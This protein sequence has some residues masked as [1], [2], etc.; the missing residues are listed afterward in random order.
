[1]IATLH[2]SDATSPGFLVSFKQPTATVL[3][4]FAMQLRSDDR[5]EVLQIGD[6]LIQ[7]EIDLAQYMRYEAASRGVSIAVIHQEEMEA[8]RAIEGLGITEEFL[9]SAAQKSQPP[10]RHLAGDQECPF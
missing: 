3:D 1:M 6:Q 2:K 9:A 7:V 8:A 4:R 5:Y 10:T